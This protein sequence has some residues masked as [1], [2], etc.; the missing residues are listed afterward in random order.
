[1]LTGT[2][3]CCAEAPAARITK[4]NTARPIFIYHTK[5]NVDRLPSE[6]VNPEEA[7]V[8]ACAAG[9][10]DAWTRFMDLYSGWILRVARS[11]FRRLT[12]ASPEAD[13]ED[14]SAEVFRQLV[15]RDRA[16]L[17]SLRPPYNLRAWLAIV[18]RRSCGKLL[19]K[20]P[21]V[22]PPREQPA[23]ASES[24]VLADLL[25]KLP[26]EERL[27]LELFFV[28]DSSYEEIGGILGMSAE[29][30]GKAKFRAL[31]KLRDLA[32]AAGMGD[33]G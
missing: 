33:L 3:C 20:K 6:P 30:V 4:R 8:R 32:R 10:P 29:S 31:E 11:S 24:G 15:D 5:R 19:R 16:M 25:Q 26:S 17:R 21:V 2:A 23:P 28:H 14:A 18:T 27:L 13:V 12:G 7:L 9:D 22:A 1:M